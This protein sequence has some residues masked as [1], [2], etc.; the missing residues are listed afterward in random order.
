VQHLRRFRE[1]L[2]TRNGDQ[3]AELSKGDIHNQM[4]SIYKKTAIVL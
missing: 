1:A 3:C 4:I 2:E